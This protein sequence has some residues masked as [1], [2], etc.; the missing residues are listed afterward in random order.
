MKT[1]LGLGTPLLTLCVVALTGCGVPLWRRPTKVDMVIYRHPERYSAFPS[2]YSS[3]KDE[4][5]VS[6]GWNTTR[7]HYGSAA[8]GK[9]G[10][11][12]FHSPDGGTTWLHRGEDKAYAAAPAKLTAF[13]LKDGTLLTIWPRMHEVMPMSRKAELEKQGVAVKVWKA[14]HISASYRVGM[15]RRAPG[16]E[17]WEPSIVK[18]PPFASMGGFG[19]GAVLR[20]GTILKPVYG[21]LRRDDK[22]NGA[23]VL[24]ST[25]NGATWQLITMAYD[26]VHSLNEAELVELPDGRVLAMIRSESGRGG[27]PRHHVGFLWQ[28]ESAD[29]GATWSTPVMTELW[30]YPPHLLLTREGDVLCTYGYRRP[31]YGIRACFSHDLGRTWD[32]ANEVILRWDALPDGPGRGKGYGGDL[33]YPRTVQLRDGTFFT[34][35]YITLGDG[36]THIA[37]TRWAR[38]TRGPDHFKRGAAAIAKPDPSAPPQLIVGEERPWRLE[39]AMIQTF[40]PRKP[41]V[42]MVAIRVSAESGLKG[43][44]HTHGLY[45]AIRKPR[46]GGWYTKVIGTSRRLKPEQIQMGG[47]N[48]FVFDK[49]VPVTPGETYALTVYNEDYTGGVGPKVRPELKGDRDWFLNSGDGALKDYP[50]GSIDPNTDIDIAFKV[51]AEPGPL[52]RE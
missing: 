16:S 42:G 38:G 45:V 51:Y 22:V 46:P 41:Q 35:Y 31:P 10:G 26:G 24:R 47:W 32:V 13:A 8:G 39:R 50:N 5:W 4:L 40:I 36:V 52:P 6:F 37:A 1:R 17:K 33:G 11:E 18:L 44:L 30:G 21:N 20:D 49:P 29:G 25:D 14:G 43:R 9:T 12:A 34:A 7:S 2:L 48:A 15:R 3:P 23:W 27:G 19:C 28:V